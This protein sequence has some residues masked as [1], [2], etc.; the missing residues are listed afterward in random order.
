MP[1]ESWNQI[2]MPEM[3]DRVYELYHENS[4]SIDQE[5]FIIPVN[6]KNGGEPTPFLMNY[7]LEIN[8]GVNSPKWIAEINDELNKCIILHPSFSLEL[9][10]IAG[11]EM[12]LGQGIYHIVPSRN[13]LGKTISNDPVPK[14]K[15][16]HLILITALFEKN[17]LLYGE[18][19]YR[20]TLLQCGE[21]IGRIGKSFEK[22]KINHNVL[23]QYNER[24]AEKLLGINGLDHAAVGAI[25]F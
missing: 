22:L 2:K 6:L 19:G 5:E 18:K 16:D 25:G 17:R 24:K 12:E 15:F 1:S 9:F 21:M 8:I 11:R 20:I 7:S 23:T 10:V 4:K 3:D 13:I 14:T